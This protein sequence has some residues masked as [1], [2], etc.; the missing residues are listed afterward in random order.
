MYPPRLNIR[1]ARRHNQDPKYIFWDWHRVFYNETMN[2]S[3]FWAYNIPNFSPLIHNQTL[4]GRNNFVHVEHLLQRRWDGQKRSD[5]CHYKTNSLP[6]YRLSSNRLQGVE[7]IFL[8][9][10]NYQMIYDG[11]KCYKKI[12]DSIRIF[13]NL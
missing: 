7:T 11:S 12:K 13:Q 1:T 5:L 8:E 2:R 10:G 4:F 9:P 3:P 6:Q